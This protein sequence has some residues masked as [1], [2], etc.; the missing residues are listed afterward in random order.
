MA[1]WLWGHRGRE[2][3][4]YQFYPYNKPIANSFNQEIKITNFII[5]FGEISSI[6]FNWVPYIDP[7]IF[8]H[9]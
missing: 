4:G 1:L 5:A 2:L 8:S 6:I 7:E 9:I 3:V